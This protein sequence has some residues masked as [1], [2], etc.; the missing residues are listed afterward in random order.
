MAA[1]LLVTVIPSPAAGASPSE[2]TV[3][4]GTADLLSATRFRED[5]GLRSDPAYVEKTLVDAAFADGTFGVPLSPAEA[6]LVLSEVRAQDAL[7][8]A[9]AAARETPGCVG[10]YF[11]RDQLTI[12]V[13]AGEAAMEATATAA[14]PNGAKVVISRVP[15]ALKDLE[16]ARS[17]IEEDWERLEAEGVSISQV[18]IDPALGR[19]RVVVGEDRTGQ[20]LELL[21]SRFGKVLAVEVTPVESSLFAGCNSIKDCGTKGGLAAKSGGW[22]C[23][24][25]FLAQE[26]GG[27]FAPVRM[28]TAGHCI[29][30]AGGVN[31]G[32]A[33][34]N[35]SATITWGKGTH[36]K[37][38]RNLDGGAFSLGS[39][40]PTT[41]NAYFAGTSDIRLV[42]GVRTNGNQVVGLTVCRSGRTSGFDCGIIRAA[43]T[44][45]TLG[46]Q[47][48]WAMWKV[49]MQSAGGDSGAGFIDL[50]SSMNAVGILSGGTREGIIPWTDYTWYSSVGDAE[51]FLK[52]KTCGTGQAPSC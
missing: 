11:V 50:A 19:V 37:F 35:E 36:Q 22:T 7:L 3:R 5:H 10:A 40:T 12:S 39:S 4:A 41:K 48:F 27:V 13:S 26:P 45:V 6:A 29:R 8:P 21:T 30:D 9:L 24:T 32:V 16:A 47:Q 25:G 44:S 34:K 52:L 17:Q 14:A 18:G 33:W 20:A 46:G 43:D 15:F 49:D 2:A 1:V 38:D 31:G 23:S 51:W 28:L 42:R